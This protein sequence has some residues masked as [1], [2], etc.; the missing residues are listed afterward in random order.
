MKKALNMIIFSLLLSSP[1]A[2]AGTLIAVASNANQESSLV[3]RDPVHSDY[4]LVF[5]D[6]GELLEV[7][8]NPYRGGPKGAGKGVAEF[9][10]Q[11]K[12]DVVVAEYFSPALTREME[13]RGI[14]PVVFKGLAREAVRRL[15]ATGNK[16]VTPS[17]GDNR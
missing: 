4:Y 9:L 17:K 16:K 3:S 10:A 2:A 12:V 5:A 1:V 13:S 8:D 6:T 7:L 15:A 11:N 14:R